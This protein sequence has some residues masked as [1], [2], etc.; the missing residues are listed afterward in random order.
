M[1]KRNYATAFPTFSTVGALAQTAW[2]AYKRYRGGSYTLDGGMARFGGTRSKFRRRYGGSRTITKRRRFRGRRTLYKKVRRINRMLRNK[3][4]TSVE[5][6]YIQ[7]VGDSGNAFDREGIFNLTDGTPG[8]GT[9]PIQYKLHFTGGI[10]KGTARS[11]RVG[12]KVFIK[13]VKFRAM[14]HHS[15]SANSADEVY[16]TIVIVRVKEAIDA[17]DS[18]VT[19]DPMLKNI[20]QVGQSTTAPNIL[21]S[22]DSRTAFVNAD[23][24][25][26]NNKRQDDYTVLYK[27]TVKVS[28]VEGSSEEKRLIRKNIRVN[29]PCWWDD[30]DHEGDGH[31]YAYW[32]S[33]VTNSTSPTTPID[34][35]RLFY[36][37]RVTYTDV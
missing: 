12:N 32:Y 24:K 21:P 14:A 18:N 1:S 16:I 26:Y 4:I 8:V 31:I 13:N 33:D 15:L 9:Y 36:G 28:K 11:Q 22:G 23:W 19:D 25:Y 17:I 3:G 10:T 34:L 7:A 30:S 20:F 6:K 27:K 5:T 35:P 29:Q 37:Y 2:N